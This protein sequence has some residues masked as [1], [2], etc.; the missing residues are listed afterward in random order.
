[1]NSNFFPSMMQNVE[2]QH[3]CHS[4]LQALYPRTPARHSSIQLALSPWP[5]IL[6]C[7]SGSIKRLPKMIMRPASQ[8][9]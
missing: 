2:L 1:M 4:G 7:T 3:R 6:Q 5:L 9:N 8:K